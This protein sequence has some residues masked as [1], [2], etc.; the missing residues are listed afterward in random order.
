M[1][2]VRL[3]PAAAA[4]APENLPEPVQEVM[5]APGA[6]EPLLSQIKA[7]LENSLEVPLA[8]VQV[9][10]DRRANAAVESR[11]TR[12]FTYGIH[13]F[14]G[15]RERPTDLALMAHEVTHVVQQQGRQ[16][17]P[18]DAGHVTAADSFEREAEQTATAVQRGDQVAVR[19]RTSGPRVQGI[20][21]IDEAA[22]WVENQAWDLLNQYAPELVPILR[23][24]PVEWLKEKISAAVEAIFNTLMGPVRAVT[25]V[26]TGLMAHFSNLLGWLRDAAARIARGDCG[27]LTEAAEKIQQVFEGLTAPVIERIKQLADRVKG[28]FSGLWERFWRASVAVPAAHRRRRVGADSAAW[29]LDLG[30][31][32]PI[33]RVLNRA[34]TWI[35][36]KLGIGEGPEGQ[37]GILQWVQHKAQAVWDQYLRPFYERFRTPILV[38]VGILALLSPAGPLIAIA[39]TWGTLAVGIRWIRQNLR[40]RSAIVQQR[41]LLE[42]MIIPGIMNAVTR[43]SAFVLEKAQF[44]SNKLT[45]VASGL[46]QAVGAVAGTIL[47][48][49][50]GILQWSIERFQE[51]VRWAI[52]QLLALA[53]MGTQR[54]GALTH[55]LGTRAELSPSRCRC[56]SQCDATAL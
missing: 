7:S 26:A 36:N 55:L 4:S 29:T 17:G 3:S 47:N 43:V 14:L 21:P 48:F 38:T 44:I 23:Q 42:G 19:E 37:D 5:R 40:N 32:T 16:V 34:W 9:H 6:G 54:A 51:L 41:G 35:K 20:W 22:Q 10:T 56:C 28:F 11:G 1:P 53:E 31:T 8:R 49:V 24:G 12:A 45:E 33:R 39:A 2:A 52:G 13:V 25:G 27:A 15:P 30:K 18:T 50:V 46:N